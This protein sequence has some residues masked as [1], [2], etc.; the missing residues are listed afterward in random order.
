MI[1]KC[2][3]LYEDSFAPHVDEERLAKIMIKNKLVLASFDKRGI[4]FPM[5]K[6]NFDPAIFT[7]IFRII[8][9]ITFE[10]VFCK[11]EKV[12]KVIYFAKDK[13][14]EFSSIEE[15]RKAL[16]PIIQNREQKHTTSLFQLDERSPG[17]TVSFY[18]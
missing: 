13:T 17:I 11:S 12:V 15:G 7:E 8:P 5:S 2:Y 4:H 10:V 1:V 9:D 3:S 16:F 18:K 6:A 14:H